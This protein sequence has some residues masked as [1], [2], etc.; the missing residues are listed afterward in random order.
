MLLM[1]KSWSDQLAPPMKS[2]GRDGR[3]TI[4]IEADP[5]HVEEDGIG[6]VAG[7][8]VAMQVER[9]QRAE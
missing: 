6:N 8:G 7:D 1:L 4:N 3:E 2:P 9:L 5:C